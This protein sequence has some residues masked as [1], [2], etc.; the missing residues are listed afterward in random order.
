EPIYPEY[1]PLKDEHILSAEEQPLPLD[2]S[3]TVESP[4]YVAESDL[5]EDP[6][7]YEDDETEDGPVDY[8]M[9]GGDDRDDDDEDSSGYDPPRKRICL[10]TLGSRYEV[11]ERSTR[12]QR[13]D[14]G[15]ADTVEAEMRH[16]G[17]REVGYGI[18]D[19]WIDLADA[20]PECWE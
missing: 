12:G 3:P 2:V 16:R 9:D 14:Y 19:A 17:N 20:V 7:E 1:I 11:G 15:F 5:D 6:N 8:P 18:R 10:L 4:G 13:V